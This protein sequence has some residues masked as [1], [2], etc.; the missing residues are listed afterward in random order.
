M[1]LVDVRKKIDSMERKYDRNFKTIFDAIRQ[2]LNPPP[3]PK[4]KRKMG[5]QDKK[6]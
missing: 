5:F 6:K 4:T 1:T 3:E 2:L